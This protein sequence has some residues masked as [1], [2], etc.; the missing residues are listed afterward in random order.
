MSVALLPLLQPR[1]RPRKRAH[2]GGTPGHTQQPHAYITQVAKGI[3]PELRV[4]GGDT[5]HPTGTGVRDYIHVMDLAAGHLAA[6]E[7]MG[8]V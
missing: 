3:L 8:P 7:K 1:G 6:L 2:R 5:P 4:F